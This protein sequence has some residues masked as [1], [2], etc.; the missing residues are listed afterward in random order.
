M[1]IWFEGKTGRAEEHEM[2]QRDMYE[3]TKRL[4]HSLV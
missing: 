3:S 2:T 4:R 1:K